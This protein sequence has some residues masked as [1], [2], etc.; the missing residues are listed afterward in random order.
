ML[1]VNRETVGLQCPENQLS[2]LWLKKST[3]MNRTMKATIIAPT[4]LTTY[5]TIPSLAKEDERNLKAYV[6]EALPSSLLVSSFPET[7]ES[8]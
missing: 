6:I 8:S 4:T 5:H 7:S 3:I 1:I 2:F